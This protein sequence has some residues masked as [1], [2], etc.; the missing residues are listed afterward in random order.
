MPVY[1]PGPRSSIERGPGAYPGVGPSASLLLAPVRPGHEPFV[2][3]SFTNVRGGSRVHSGVVKL[4][5][6]KGVRLR[7]GEYMTWA[8]KVPM[9]RTREQIDAQRKCR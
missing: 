1:D 2:E 3:T 6:L 4:D 5:A 9:V 8:G 7:D